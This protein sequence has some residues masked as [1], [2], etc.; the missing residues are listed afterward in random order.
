MTTPK[1]RMAN[2]HEAEV[3]EAFGGQ[4]TPMSGAG[5][6]SKQDVR[7]DTELIECKA[8]EAASY[9]VKFELL[10]ALENNALLCGRRPILDIKF[11]P[12]GAR[13][14]RYVVVPEDD[15]L[16]LRNRVYGDPA[17]CRENN[18]CDKHQA[19]G[20]HYAAGDQ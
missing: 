16:A 7:T 3:A 5:W 6:I 10:R 15:Y 18:W 11:Q 13:P 2:K 19:F 1:Q 12:P 20:V 4:V 17:H 8:T 14:K 9:S